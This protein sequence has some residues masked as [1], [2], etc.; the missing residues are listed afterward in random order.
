MAR[1]KKEEEELEETTPAGEGAPGLH[2]LNFEARRIEM[3]I[4]ACLD[5]PKEALARRQAVFGDR[6]MEVPPA[7][8]FEGID[9]AIDGNTAGVVKPTGAVLRRVQL[10]RQAGKLVRRY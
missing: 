4:D 6:G 3:A 7:R 10:R 1:K 5:F 2:A 8:F 9:N